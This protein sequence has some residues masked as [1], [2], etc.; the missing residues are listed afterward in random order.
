[1]LDEEHNALLLDPTAEDGLEEWHIYHRKGKQMG[2]IQSSLPNLAPLTFEAVQFLSRDSKT[3]RFFGCRACDF[4]FWRTVYEFKPVARCLKC[5]VKLEAVPK[6]YE[7]GLGHFKCASGHEFT[8]APCRWHEVQNCPECGQYA[9]PDRVSR[10]PARTEFSTY[11]RPRCDSCLNGN[12]CERHPYRR[13][14][15]IHDS[16][17]ST[18]TDLTSVASFRGF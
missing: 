2:P 10:G 15:D 5:R 13:Y 14:S 11:R 1:M 16:T 9:K 18:E 3:H 12:G 8:K 7:I 17:G 6:E 4:F